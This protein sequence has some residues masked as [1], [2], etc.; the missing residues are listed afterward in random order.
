MGYEKHISMWVDEDK[1]M[2]NISDHNLVRAWFNIGGDNTP[3]QHKKLVKEITWISREPGR[4][5]LCAE[6]F[7]TKIGKRCSF[8]KC[9]GKV[10]SSMEYAMRRKLKK[11]KGKNKKYIMK[12]AT[13]VDEELL[14]NINHRSKLSREWR[15]ARKRGESKETLEVYKEEYETQKEITANMVSQK[16]GQWE[17][18]KIEETK[19]NG[20]GLWKMIR[21]LIGKDKEES[22]EAFIYTEEGEKIEI[23]QCRKEFIA[24]WTAK[25]YQKLEKADFNFWYDKVKG[26]KKRMMEEMTDPESG[27]IEN[28]IISEEEF[29]NTINKMKNNKAS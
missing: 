15:Y 17:I 21:E 24:E 4:I 22:E 10:R 28:P 2:L 5:K 14:R 9:I 3:K 11:K 18:E 23:G 8:K 12:A 6:N 1:T 29:V 26:E 16:K 27:I 13:W 25:V 20:K 19:D 7:K